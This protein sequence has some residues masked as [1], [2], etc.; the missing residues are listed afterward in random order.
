MAG[1]AIVKPGLKGFNKHVFFKESANVGA[2]P[3]FVCIQTVCMSQFC[4]AFA[5]LLPLLQQ[6][7]G[8]FIKSL[9]FQLEGWIGS[10]FCGTSLTAFTFCLRQLF[11]IFKSCS[12]QFTF[13]VTVRQI[14]D[15]IPLIGSTLQ[16]ASVKACSSVCFLISTTDCY[17]KE[18]EQPQNVD[19]FS[20]WLHVQYGS[21]TPSA[22]VRHLTIGSGLP[23]RN[24]A[25][26]LDPAAAAD[27]V[28]RLVDTLKQARFFILNNL[29]IIICLILKKFI[30]QK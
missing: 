26:N 13:S 29:I 30:N 9:D 2:I 25:L 28:E 4:P 6:F 1:V 22:P 10:P 5:R 14:E 24:C 3:A 21:E 8:N 20:D 19:A 18:T 15:T 7:S 12:P 17:L 27:F 11:S 23:E 16:L